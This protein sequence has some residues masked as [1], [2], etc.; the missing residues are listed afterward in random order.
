MIRNKTQ[1]GKRCYIN[2]YPLIYRYMVEAAGVEPASENAFIEAS[3][4]AFRFLDSA[5]AL[6]RKESHARSFIGYKRA[7]KA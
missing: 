4:S 5:R 3:P 2:A 7:Y 1:E 6:Q